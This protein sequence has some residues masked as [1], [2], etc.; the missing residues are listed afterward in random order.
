[1]IDLGKWAGEEHRIAG[2]STHIPTEE[3]SDFNER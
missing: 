2:E 3:E 1:M